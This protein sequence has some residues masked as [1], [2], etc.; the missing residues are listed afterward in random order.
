MGWIQIRYSSCTNTPDLPM[1][2][3]DFFAACSQAEVSFQLPKASFVPRE[4]SLH[5]LVRDSV[6]TA[7]T[8]IIQQN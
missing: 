8:Q 7:N 1:G 4:Q 2:D 3:E 6:N 5:L